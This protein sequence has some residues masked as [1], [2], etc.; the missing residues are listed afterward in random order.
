MCDVVVVVDVVDDDDDATGDVTSNCMYN[1]Y[2]DD[3][4]DNGSGDQKRD[5]D[6]R[7][8]SAAVDE[9]DVDD[10]DVIDIAT[11]PDGCGVREGDGRG[12]RALRRPLVAIRRRRRVPLVN[13]DVT[14][15]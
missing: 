11:T 10:D 1:H 7:S 15:P 8:S 3:D 4:D 6:V 5:V 9:Y 2:D 13:D 14:T 12:V